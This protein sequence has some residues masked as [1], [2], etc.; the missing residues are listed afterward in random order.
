MSL[1][2]KINIV[3]SNKELNYLLDVA[4]NSLIIMRDYAHTMKFSKKTVRSF[5]EL[6]ATLTIRALSPYVSGKLTEKDIKEILIGA[7]KINEYIFGKSYKITK[8]IKQIIFVVYLIF[9]LYIFI[10]FADN[11]SNACRVEGLGPTLYRTGEKVYASLWSKQQLACERSQEFGAM[12]ISTLGLHIATAF[13]PKEKL[14]E[15][16]KL[17]GISSTLSYASYIPRPQDITNTIVDVIVQGAQTD[18]LRSTISEAVSSVAPTRPLPQPT[19]SQIQQRQKQPPQRS[20]PRM[21]LDE[22]LQMQ[23]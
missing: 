2:K 1:E 7:D 13:L 15:F 17:P 19:Q 6:A 5:T 23:E 20:Q 12:G 3:I 11:Y 21:S 4:A 14:K 9:L 22:M 8:I 16:A 18:E 10:N